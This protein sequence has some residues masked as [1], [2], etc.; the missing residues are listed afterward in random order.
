MGRCVVV[1]NHIPVII[2]RLPVMVDDAVDDTAK[3]IGDGIRDVAW[4]RTGLAISTTRSKTNG[5]RMHSQVGIGYHQGPAFYV[6]FQE[7]GAYNTWA[8]R[9]LGPDPRVTPVAHQH[10]PMLRNEVAEAVRGACSV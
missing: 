7:F 5:R 3:A 4:H 8:G 2:K 6:I 1:Y 9:R 10:E